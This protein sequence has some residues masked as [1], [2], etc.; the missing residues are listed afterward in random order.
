MRRVDVDAKDIL[1]NIRTQ[2]MTPEEKVLYLEKLRVHEEEMEKGKK[3]KQQILECIKRQQTDLIKVVLFGDTFFIDNLEG[4][5]QIHER[6]KQLD[7]YFGII[8]N[9]P[10]LYFN[11]PSKEMQQVVENLRKMWTSSKIGVT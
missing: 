4:F 11:A 2:K 10:C 9:M 7:Y 8:D 1:D 6:C 5:N 3:Q